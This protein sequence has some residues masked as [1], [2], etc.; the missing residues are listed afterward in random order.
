MELPQ[1]TYKR[2]KL[3]TIRILCFQIGKEDVARRVKL[4]WRLPGKGRQEVMQ[5]RQRRLWR[6]SG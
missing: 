6:M 4:R 5:K 2:L 3:V 1:C